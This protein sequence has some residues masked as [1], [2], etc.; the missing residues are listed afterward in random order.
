VLAFAT[1]GFESTLNA[2]PHI[3]VFSVIPYYRDK[4]YFVQ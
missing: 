1:T 4:A 3:V 2:D